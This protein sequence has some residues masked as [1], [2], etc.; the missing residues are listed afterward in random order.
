MPALFLQY[1]WR[2]HEIICNYKYKKLASRQAEF[3][4]RVRDANERFY[5]PQDVITDHNRK[6]PR[7]QGFS[8]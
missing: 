2:L 7:P 6:H 1:Q 4:A 3:E 8:F 5:C